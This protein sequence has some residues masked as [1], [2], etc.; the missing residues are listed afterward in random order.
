MQSRRSGEAR[1]ETRR[2]SEADGAKGMGS[3]TVG[4]GIWGKSPLE[5]G[6]CLGWLCGC[7]GGGAQEGE[8]T[9]VAAATFPPPLVLALPSCHPR[10]Q[11][12]Q[13]VAPSVAA[14]AASPRPRRQR[15]WRGGE[16]GPSWLIPGLQSLEWRAK[17]MLCQDPCLS[18]AL[19]TGP[20]DSSPLSSR[21]E[22]FVH[23]VF[24]AHQPRLVLVHMPLWVGGVAAQSPWEPLP[25]LKVRD[26]PTLQGNQGYK[27]VPARC[28]RV[29]T[30]PLAIH[31][32]QGGVLPA[33]PGSRW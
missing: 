15:Q 22:R 10:P 6:S 29:S 8:L 32:D 23:L 5:G 9:M 27:R 25:N 4:R 20:Q 2:G 33:S 21:G 28:P 19:S 30:H 24:F 16:A 31:P 7:P 11:A 14:A 17:R 12:H 26:F 1:Q 3:L 18:G 13:R